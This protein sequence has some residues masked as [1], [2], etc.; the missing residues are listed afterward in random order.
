MHASLW[1]YRRD[2]QKLIC[3]IRIACVPRS[4]CKE[5]FFD[6]FTASAAQL[7]LMKHRHC[8]FDD[9]E[10]PAREP[11][12]VGYARKEEIECKLFGLEVLDPLLGS[13]SMVDPCEGSWDLPY[14]VRN[15]GYEWFFKRHDWF[16]K[17]LMMCDVVD[18]TCCMGNRRAAFDLARKPKKLESFQ[19][20]KLSHLRSLG[21]VAQSKQ[22]T[23]FAQ[24]EVDSRKNIQQ[25]NK[26]RRKEEPKLL[27][28]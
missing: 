26:F 28:L 21:K 19:L 9:I 18:I 16:S 27:S 15:D 11:M 6:E 17:L 22:M 20:S 3:A 10:S 25:I 2:M 23:N 12:W 7:L 13:Q 5:S 14:A 4:E 24:T 1:F 8:S